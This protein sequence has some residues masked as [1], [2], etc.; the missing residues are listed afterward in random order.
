M[1]I[2]AAHVRT[3]RALLGWT[4]TELARRSK[5]GLSTI[6]EFEVGR[7]T[8]LPE[9]ADAIEIALVQAGVEFLVRGVQLRTRK[10]RRWPGENHPL[11]RSACT[12]FE[13]GSWVS[14]S[15]RIGMIASDQSNGTD[16]FWWI[17]FGAS[18]PYELCRKDEVRLATAEERAVA[19]GSRPRKVKAA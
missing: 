19:T 7:R 17:Q 14:V 9:H 12:S 18:G 6:Y 11:H 8:P 13:P 15:G 16:E 4:Q 3:A 10:K 1:L 5:V 2:T